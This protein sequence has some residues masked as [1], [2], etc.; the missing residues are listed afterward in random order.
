MMFD[1]EEEEIFNNPQA[2]L[3]RNSPELSFVTTHTSKIVGIKCI[4]KR[5]W[6]GMARK[7]NFLNY[8]TFIQE[9]KFAKRLIIKSCTLWTM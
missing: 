7:K 2:G 9:K 4:T 1:K 5:R 6:H 8:S 3:P